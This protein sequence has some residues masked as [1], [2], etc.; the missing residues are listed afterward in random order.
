MAANW[1]YTQRMNSVT[2]QQMSATHGFQRYN[3]AYQENLMQRQQDWTRADWAYQDTMSSLS[4]EWG[5]EDVNEAIRGATGRQRRN[6]IRQRDRMTTKRNLEQEHTDEVRDRQEELWAM[7]EERFEKQVEYQETL[8]DL[9][10]E[11]FKVNK[12]HQATMH[13]IQVEDFE[14]A[15][16]EYEEQRALQEEMKEL[17]REHQAEMMELQEKAIGIQAA[18]AAEQYNINKILKEEVL[19]PSETKVKELERALKNGS[20]IPQALDGLTTLSKSIGKLDKGQIDN[21]AD[22]FEEM[23]KSGSGATSVISFLDALGNV[24][25][26]KI[27]QLIS[28]LRELE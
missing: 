17:Q 7:Q 24:S 8:M 9:E 3:F 25:P 10:E 11:R 26:F 15:K 27:Q 18:A 23:R 4:F 28:L 12:Q 20:D 21:L 22:V 2:A 6:L 14:R 19:E 1:A 13:S 16:K 5:L